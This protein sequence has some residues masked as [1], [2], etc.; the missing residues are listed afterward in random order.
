MNNGYPLRSVASLPALVPVTPFPY[1]D[2]PLKRE[3]AGQCFQ[4]VNACEDSNQKKNCRPLRGTSEM[5]Q[6]V[7]ERRG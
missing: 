6:S 3:S 7:M 2:S 5:K 4:I 1:G